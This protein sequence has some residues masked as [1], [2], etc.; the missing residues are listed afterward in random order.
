[1]NIRQVCVDQ[2]AIQHKS[3]VKR[4]PLGTL[5]KRILTLLA[6][7][8]F[9]TLPHMQ[10]YAG[11]SGGTIV[12]GSG[13]ITQGENTTLVEQYS[14]RLAIDWRDF[15]VGK[16]ERVTFQQPSSSSTA[17]NRIFDQNPS[18]IFGAIEANGRIYLMNPN[19]LIIGESARIDV[20]S[21]VA[22]SL[23]MNLDDF[24]L[25]NDQFDI[26][27][28]S[29][30]NQGVIQAAIGGS[31]N[32]VGGIVKNEG[33]IIARAGQVNLASGRKLTLD[34]DGDGL[35]RFEVSGEVLENARNLDSAV[36]NSGSIEASDVLLSATV[37]RD[38]F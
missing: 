28:G 38:V 9:T 5:V 2:Q 32:L 10:A 26:G 33:I 11:P 34:F 13:S 12:G 19:G 3:W 21:L 35:M 30:I 16:G 17:L 24:M 20:A 23:T 15:N 22:G 14:D 7:F 27:E 29:V 4:K 25:G 31:V 6:S 37:A 8:A 36:S 1:M 18:Q